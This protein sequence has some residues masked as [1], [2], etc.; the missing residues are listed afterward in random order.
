MA[1][2]GLNCSCRVIARRAFEGL[3]LCSEGCKY[4]L[5]VLLSDAVICYVYT[6]SVIWWMNGY[7]A[8]AKWYWQGGK[9][10]TDEKLSQCLF[11]QFKF[12]MDWTGI[13]IGPTRRLIERTVMW[14]SLQLEFNVLLMKTACNFFYSTGY[15]VF[16]KQQSVF[17]GLDISVR[18]DWRATEWEGS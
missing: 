18:G 4:F 1:S 7:G 13:E 6:V 11:V 9:G 14:R 16:L 12:R 10:S 17:I 5:S 2:E 8:L 3:E 15:T